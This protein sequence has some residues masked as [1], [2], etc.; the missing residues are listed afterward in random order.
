LSCIR[1]SREA[2][3]G[4]VEFTLPFANGRVERSEGIRLFGLG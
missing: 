2:Q 4:E 1:P 3:E